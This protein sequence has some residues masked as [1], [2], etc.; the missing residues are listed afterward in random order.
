MQFFLVLYV[1]C[2]YKTLLP[3]ILETLE[4]MNMKIK[5]SFSFNFM[6][7]YVWIMTKFYIRERIILKDH[8]NYMSLIIPYTKTILIHVIPC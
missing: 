2:N 4:T 6:G 5:S 8:M 7:K 3:E 1:E